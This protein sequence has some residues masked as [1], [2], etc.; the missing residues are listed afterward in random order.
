[1]PYG[2]IYRYEIIDDKPV[3]VVEIDEQAQEAICLAIEL[4]LRRGLGL[5]LIA[6]ELA[7]RGFRAPSGGS[8]TRSSLIV[9]LDMIWRY[10]G[11]VELNKRSTKRT[12]IRAKSR[13]PALISEADAKAVIAERQRRAGAKRSVARTHIFSQVVWCQKCNRKM[14]VGHDK[15]RVNFRCQDNYGRPI[16]DRA[17]I[18]VRFIEEAI[19]AAIDYVQDERNREQLAGSKPDASGSLRLNIERTKER[20][21]KQDEAIQRADDAYVMGTMDIDRYQRQIDRLQEQR[22]KL[23]AEL[24]RH[25]SDLDAALF[26]SQRLNRLLEVATVGRAMLQSNDIATANAWWQRHLRVWVQN[27]QDVRVT[28]EYL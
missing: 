14:K 23:E 16:H 12:Y 18:A 28:V 4:Y 11:Y 22:K 3:Q 20:L 15:E 24:E 19:M 13:W 27:D 17:S 2:W 5:N 8:W 6:D 25:E 7:A 26:D 1:V 10:A 21:K 9:M